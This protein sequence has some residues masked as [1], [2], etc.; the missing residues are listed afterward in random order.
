MFISRVHAHCLFMSFFAAV[1]THTSTCSMF[2]TMLLQPHGP[3]LIYQE[4]RPL[5]QKPPNPMSENG[6]GL[7]A[8]VD[9]I[10]KCTVGALIIRIAFWGIIYKKYNKEPPK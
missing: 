10:K 5:G 2:R 9:R 4:R 1:H 6:C 8:I 7:Q 3:T